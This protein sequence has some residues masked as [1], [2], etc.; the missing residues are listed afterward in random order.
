MI[1]H[2]PARRDPT[3][4]TRHGPLLEELARHP[5]VRLD[6]QGALDRLLNAHIEA[7]EVQFDIAAVA[8][9]YQLARALV[10]RGLGVTITDEVTAR[11]RGPGVVEVTPLKPEVGFRIAA[12][13]A[14]NESVS[15]LCQDFVAHLKASMR[16][17]LE[18]SS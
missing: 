14:D 15:R 17:F 11:S 8:G 5:F 4:Q 12:L 9:S 16:R 1:A 3:R 6:N 10:A 7:S 2:E 13:H 18:C